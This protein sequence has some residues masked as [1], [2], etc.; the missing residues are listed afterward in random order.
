MRD[1]Q[2]SAT[3]QLSGCKNAPRSRGKKPLPW[4]NEEL[5]P[6]LLHKDQLGKDQKISQQSGKESL[7]VRMKGLNLDF[8]DLKVGKY[9]F[10]QHRFG[11]IYIVTILFP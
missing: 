9:I 10:Y 7:S 6:P 11:Y 8:L 2:E 4:R 1:V 5:L 3:R